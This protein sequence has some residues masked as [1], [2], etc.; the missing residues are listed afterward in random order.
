MGNFLKVKVQNLT[1]LYQ[2]SKVKNGCKKDK[3]WSIL[4][5]SIFKRMN[6]FIF[7]APILLPLFFLVV[8]KKLETWKKYY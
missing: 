3:G 1:K 8:A 7:V 5:S 2:Q 6:V 4:Y